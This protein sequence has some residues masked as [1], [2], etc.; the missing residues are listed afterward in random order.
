E[1]EV[2]LRSLPAMERRLQAGEVSEGVLAIP[3][4]HRTSL[5]A[6]SSPANLPRTIYNSTY[7]VGC[8][9]S[10][11]LGA[12][13]LCHRAREESLVKHTTSSWKAVRS[14]TL[15]FFAMFAALLVHVASAED[16]TSPPQPPNEAIHCAWTW[17]P[18]RI[19]TEVNFDVSLSSTAETV[20]I[21]ISNIPTD[22]T[23]VT[24]IR[25]PSSRNPVL[26]EWSPS[27]LSL[28]SDRFDELAFEASGTH[29]YT[30]IV[31][32]ARGRTDGIERCVDIP[33]AMVSAAP[34]EEAP[35]SATPPAPFTSQGI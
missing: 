1:A 32:N 11:T 5:S 2:S 14:S 8:L 35:I 17:L 26:F 20:A 19:A 4:G 28:A 34:V 9:R 18:E 33:D 12:S 25:E 30:L 21:S 22:V 31:G 13:W 16:D 27:G 29:C 24:V 10:T 7:C 3:I 23:C 6:P 15:L